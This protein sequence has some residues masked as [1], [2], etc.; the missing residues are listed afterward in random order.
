[1]QCYIDL[2][3]VK[4]NRKI[5]VEC[6]DLKAPKTGKGFRAALQDLDINETWVITP[7]NAATK[8]IIILQ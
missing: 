6:K 1:M 4:G 3:F 5:A 2:I 7:V 8:S